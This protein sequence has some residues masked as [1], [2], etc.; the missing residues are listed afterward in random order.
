MIEVPNLSPFSPADFK[1]K[2]FPLKK[3]QAGAII[4][5]S[6]SGPQVKLDP[7]TWLRPGVCEG[8]H[9]IGKDDRSVHITG[10]KGDPYWDWTIGI[11]RAAGM[12]VLEGFTIHMSAVRGIM[13]GLDSA[14]R[15]DVEPIVL[16]L[17]NCLIVDD[18]SG[19]WAIHRYMTLLIMEEVDFECSHIGEHCDYGH[20][21]V[22]YPGI[23]FQE[24]VARCTFKGG[25][26]ECSKHTARPR[27]EFYEGRPQLAQAKH[28]A[29]D[30]C[31][32]L[33]SGRRPRIF[34]EDNVYSGLGTGFTMQ[35]TGA[36]FFGRRLIFRDNR[37]GKPAFAVDDSG[38]EHFSAQEPTRAGLP[39]AN[40]RVVLSE[41]LIESDGLSVFPLVR[42]GSL[43][44]SW[45]DRVAML[46][47][48]D[49]CGIYGLNA[50]VRIESLLGSL[51]QP[52]IGELRVD[53]CNTPEIEALARA[54]GLFAWDEAVLQYPG[55]P[56]TP[57]SAGFVP[58]IPRP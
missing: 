19:R 34:H 47:W 2:E 30:G 7:S 37:M 17:R 48:L 18:G 8:A 44:S 58:A 35:G 20:G 51:G 27:T 56:L 5:W 52:C 33:P 31:R 53:G 54:S 49:R 21:N 11:G 41:C 39:D 9:F 38:V 12:V 28:R 40:G 50:A 26:G 15:D 36:D 25:W 22:E 23:P 13:S 1:L 4:G 43:N 10:K 46:L 55:L 3:D 45:P 32:P 16:W 24:Y 14:N 29:E 57:L 6:G 42:L